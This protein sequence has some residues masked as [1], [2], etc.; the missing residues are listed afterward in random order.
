M[1]STPQAL[2]E[3]TTAA[4]TEQKKADVKQQQLPA[5]LIATG[6]AGAETVTVYFT[7]DDGVTWSPAYQKTEQVILTATN[8]TVSV[9]SPITIG[10]LKAAS[11]SAVGVFL[12]QGTNP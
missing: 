2:I 5:T 7:G 12:S 8:N 11:V 3:P 10:V 4:V 6:L 1:G 9:N